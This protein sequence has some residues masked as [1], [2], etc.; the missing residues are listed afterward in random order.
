MKV[1]KPVPVMDT[2]LVS[3][4][5]P[6]NDYA[7]WSSTTAYPTIGT[8]VVWK[9]RIWEST[10]SVPA[11]VEP[12]NEVV[13]KDNPAKWADQGATNRWRMFDDK[14]ESLTVNPGSIEV[15]VRPG[16]L[17][18]GLALLNLS[19]R[20][21][22]VRMV[23]PVDGVVY[24]K[25]RTLVDAGVTNWY[26]WFFM[27]IDVVTD[28]TFLDLPPYGT[29]DIY[30]TIEAGSGNAEV[31]HVTMGYQIELGTALYGSSVGIIDYST[32]STDQF[33]N[34]TVTRRA[35]SNRADFDMW[36]DTK[37]VSRMR[38]TLAEL[39]AVPVLWVGVE[40]D[41]YEATTLFG[42]YKDF[43]MVY[44]GPEVSEGSITVEAII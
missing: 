15:R 18:N 33:G 11:G 28:Q 38:R 1:V 16:S 27:P 24:D 39:R 5:V 40:E 10:A 6:E 31:G 12:G 8:R 42:Y 4:N 41:G 20:S 34:T 29:A 43:T 25:T 19:G 37:S 9:H 17:V 21:V 23:D 36:F 14:V 30:I 35:Y 7:A 2:N 13:D 3:S 32:K 22:R 26:D 44:S